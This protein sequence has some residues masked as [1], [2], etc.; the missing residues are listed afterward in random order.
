MKKKFCKRTAQAESEDDVKMEPVSKLP[1][2]VLEQFPVPDSQAIHRKYLEELKFFSRKILVLDDDPTG[3]QTVHDVHVY[4]DW[5]EESLLEGM[6]EEG[7]LFFVLT[8]SRSFSEEETRREHM[9]LARRAARAARQS[10]KELLV[11]SRGDSTLRGHYPLEMEALGE[12]LAQE[13]GKAFNGQ[14]LCPFFRE[15]GR[16]TIDGVHYVRE[17][18]WLVPVGETEFARD[19]TF[20]FHSSRLSDYVE[21]K[22]RGRYRKENSLS[23]TLSVLRSPSWESITELLMKAEHFQ[24][25]LV[26]AIDSCDVEAFAVCLLRA[27]RRGKE[28]LIRGAAELPRVLGNISHRPL[29]T[30]EELLGDGEGEATGAHSVYGGIVLIGSHVRKTTRQ[31]QSLQASDVAAEFLEFHAAACLDPEDAGQETRR[32]IRL[33]EEAMSRGRAAV[34]Y[35]SRTVLAPEGFSKEE[36]LRL[37]V[38]ISDALTGVIAGLTRK[39]GFLIAKGGITSSD[40]GT[41]ALRVRKALVLGQIRPGIPVWRTGEESKFPGLPYIIFPGNVGDVDTLRDIVEMLAWKKPKPE[42]E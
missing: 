36:A 7:P 37:S 22:S 1:L 5:T 24:P 10:G 14:I 33:A 11:I 8:N 27:I 20:G 2:S 35:T 6:R 9:L 16:Y 28:F 23:I 17:G 34:V 40:V 3:V 42:R 25:I 32:L 38:R 31:L 12:V 41:K 18:E 4:T 29:L 13:T 15:G 21:E 19:K 30:R 39:P 26:D